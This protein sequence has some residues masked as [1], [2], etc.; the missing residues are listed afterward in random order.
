MGEYQYVM[1][2]ENTS[3]EDLPGVGGKGA[4]L[5]EIIKAG[6][7]VPGGFVVL[8]GAYYKFIAENNLKEKISEFISGLD[9]T[10]LEQVEEISSKIKELFATGEIPGDVL[11]EIGDIYRT[12][13]QPSVAVR[14]SATAEDLP[15][16]SFAGQ[17]DTYLNVTGTGELSKSIKKCWASIWNTRALSYRLKQ[18][19]GS[20][21]LAHGVVVQKMVDAEKSGILF[22]ANPVNGR[23]DQV[24]L[25]SSWGLGEAIVSGDVDPDQWVIAKE[26]GETISEY[27]ATKKVM[28]VRKDKDVELVEVEP[29]RQ[30]EATLNENEIKELLFLARKVEEHYGFPQ[31]LEWAC[32]NGRF[33]LVQTRPITSLFPLPEPIDGDKGFRVYLNF[34]LYTQAMLEPFTPIGEAMLKEMLSS[35]AKRIYR[36]YRNQEVP[37]I[38][39][40]ARRVFVD[41]TG[42]LRN[43]K[44]IHNL[45]GSPNDKDPVTTK[46]LL[47]IFERNE[48]DIMAGKKGK[49]STLKIL[50]KIDP[51]VLKFAITTTHKVMYGKLSPQKARFK[52]VEY[53]ENKIRA[54]AKESRSLTTLE[55]KLNFI[56]RQGLNLFISLFE[57]VF[58][59]AVS[60]TYIKKAETTMRKHLDD[61]SELYK[62]EKAL[63]YNVTTEMGIELLRIAKTLADKGE[64]PDPG[65][66]EIQKFLQKY[67]HR[68][69][70]EIDLGVLK[71]EEDPTYIVDLIQSYIDHKTYDEGLVKYYRAREEAE[72]A[73]VNIADKLKEKRA[74]KDARKVEKLLRDYRE[75]FGVRELPKYYLTRAFSILRDIL[76]DIGEE[77]VARDRI[78]DK[79]DVFYINFA[80]IRSG[81]KL[82][83]LVKKNKEDYTREL[84]RKVPRIITST[85]ES[86]YSTLEE[87]EK[88]DTLIGI[89]VSPGV[90]EGKVRLLMHPE[91]GVKL[92]RG[93]IMATKATT[94]AWTPLFLNIG[95][96]IME[97]GGPISHG[98]VVARE[99][100]IP[101][102][103]G[104][105]DLTTRLKDG[106][107]IR[108]NG[109]TGR[110]QILSPEQK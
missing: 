98:S 56:E 25:S 79:M 99:Y 27:I 3:K 90:C 7:P 28:T 26:T 11:A 68:S 39:S 34:N 37:W 4:N 107:K 20:K 1:L 105:N 45:E 19:I 87:E 52:A 69:S 53:G 104:V 74:G 36:G 32:E 82:Q 94:P 85:G 35:M 103:A 30:D 78:A 76:K 29:D 33:Y 75:M 17:Y 83:D 54:I 41:F 23:R 51:W 77:L 84:G 24:S 89:P 22:T 66:E 80:D 40:A 70:I 63:P 38:K 81:E 16:T 92:G 100:G 60:S 62:V 58:F 13:D 110:I 71:W 5:G 55:N 9:D 43:Q 96:L 61:V 6:L 101:A 15:G 108:I 109:E 42:L 44:F 50:A 10:N 49:G 12:L 86:I 64:R 93:E 106:Q 65:N 91:E 102:V 46:A 18:K 67:G 72:E 57:V 2:L 88:E 97:T 73:I 21:E 14:S 95:G 47:Q 8:T 48:Q 31:D 59:V